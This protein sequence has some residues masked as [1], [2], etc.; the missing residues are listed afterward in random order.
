MPNYF[1]LLDG[2]TQLTPVVLCGPSSVN[3][4]KPVV[5]NV[6]HCASLRHGQWTLSVW[7]SDSPLDAPPAW[8]VRYLNSLEVDVDVIVCF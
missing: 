1:A 6:Q 7:A 4:L 5:L 2:M 3:L 8:N